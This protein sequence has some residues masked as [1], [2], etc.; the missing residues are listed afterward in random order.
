MILMPLES[1]LLPDINRNRIGYKAWISNY[2][3][4]KQC[5]MIVIH[6]VTLTAVETNHGQSCDMD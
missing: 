5:N 1:L 4:I 3:Y 2:I 6:A